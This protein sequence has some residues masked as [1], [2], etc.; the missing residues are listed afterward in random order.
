L[1]EQRSLLPRFVRVLWWGG[2]CLALGWC[3]PSTVRAAGEALPDQSSVIAMTLP[4]GLRIH[5]CVRTF[6]DLK[7]ERAV[8]QKYDFSCGAAALT[9]L[10]RH[11]YKLNVSEESVVEF[12]IHK[13]GPEEAI[14]RYK[15]KKGFSLLD[16][17]TA[18]ASVGFKS[19]AYSEMTLADLVGLESPAI[20]PIRTRTYDHF[21]VFRGLREDRVFLMDPIIG[22]STM[23]A[24]NFVDA[25]RNGVGMLLKSKKGLEPTN[26]QPEATAQGF[27]SE[28][29]TR[30]LLR[31]GGLGFVPRVAGEF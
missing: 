26:W 21:V 30:S 1:R 5:K 4:S 22:N 2:L 17:K 12:I 14:R 20:V 28:D 25:W 15:E 13:R 7:D 9:T 8:R 16:L 27:V 31:A 19:V 11:Y 6:K 18:A 3:C 29:M 24:G 23:K 10:L